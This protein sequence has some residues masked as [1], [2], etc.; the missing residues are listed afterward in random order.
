MINFLRGRKSYI[1]GTGWILWG[2]WTYAVEGDQP[3]GIQRILE[4]VGLITLRAGVKKVESARPV[5]G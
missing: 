1:I 5:A 4:G 2:V 3:T